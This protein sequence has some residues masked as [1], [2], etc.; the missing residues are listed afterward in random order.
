MDDSNVSFL[1]YI[2][3]QRELGD[4]KREIEQIMNVE[5]KA[6]VADSPRST[7]HA[8][9]E[10][11]VLGLYISLRRAPPW[12]TANI[13]R[14]AGGTSTRNFSTTGAQLS[15]DAHVARALA[16][17]GFA[18]VMSRDEFAKLDPDDSSPLSC[19]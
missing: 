7:P 5:L 14:F 4:I 19:P 15:I 10:A 17:G 12:P 9:F 18:R 11:D 16:R 8:A 3:D 13:Y 1:L 6:E 2:E